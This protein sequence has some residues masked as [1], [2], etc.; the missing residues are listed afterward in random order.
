MHA[1][2]VVDDSGNVA[3]VNIFENRKFAKDNTERYLLRLI[4]WPHEAIQARAFLPNSALIFWMM[5]NCSAENQSEVS[6]LEVK[7]AA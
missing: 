5:Y 6:S 2:I 1:R 7:P 4:V 3:L